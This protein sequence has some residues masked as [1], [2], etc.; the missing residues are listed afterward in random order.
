[1]WLQKKKKDWFFIEFA[2]E[3]HLVLQDI[4]FIYKNFIHWN[5]SK[6]LIS[7]LSILLGIICALPF[8]LVTVIGAFIDPV[9]WLNMLW[10]E[11]ISQEVLLRW[12]AWHPYWI[13]LI[14]FLSTI[15]TV[16]FLLG[17]SYGSFLLAR[18]SGKYVQRKRLEYKKNLYFSFVHLKVYI[19]IISWNALYLMA[20]ILIWGGCIFFLYLIYNIWYMTF[21]WLSYSLL[22]LTIILI[23]ALSY[24]CYRL[25]FSYF[26]AAQEKKSTPPLPAK[27]YVDTSI[28]LTGWKSFWK[29]LF[30]AM[31][32]FIILSP[33][34]IIEE[35]LTVEIANMRDAYAYKSENLGTIDA[36]QMQYYE[37]ITKEYE[38]YSK[39]DLLDKVTLYSR[40]KIVHFF[41]TYFL[42]GWLFLLII[43]SFYYRILLKN[44]LTSLS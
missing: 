3:V 23:A 9:P 2:S 30:L 10:A 16:F 38:A 6:I 37:Y 7:V 28:A 35:K 22:W 15:S 40:F 27:S 33:F 25:G 36:T 14:I 19:A 29:F 1:M 17:S 12:L 24:M 20:P 8:I 26:I 11:N 31:A 32:Y 4:L 34:N 39:E 21:T 13:V 18:L 42:F 5:I 41:L 43:T 44:E